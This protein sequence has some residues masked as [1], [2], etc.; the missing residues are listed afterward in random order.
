MGTAEEDWE[1]IAST[2]AHGV[3]TSQAD[4][5]V[6]EAGLEGSDELTWLPCST[7]TSFGTVTIF[8]SIRTTVAVRKD[9]LSLSIRLR[10]TSI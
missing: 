1:C 5:F 4:D 7:G 10:T 9:R 3:S 2:G 6:S 8:S